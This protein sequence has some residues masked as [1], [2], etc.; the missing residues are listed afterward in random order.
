M[1]SSFGK[2]TLAVIVICLM[3]LMP[4][5]VAM[6][7]GCQKEKQDNIVEIDSFNCEVESKQHLSNPKIDE[8]ELKNLIIERVEQLQEQNYGIG[9]I[10]LNWTDP[11]GPL[12][13]GLDDIVDYINLIFGIAQSG[14]LLKIIL[15]GYI[16]DS[17]TFY[18]FILWIILYAANALNILIVFG[19]AFDVFEYG[20][21]DGR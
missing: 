7:D 13:G 10:G 3:M 4:L 12:E 21:G 16:R 19:E 8:D 14:Y 20:P 1:K 2:K 15:K 11:D 5:P 9:I 17:S 6:A 18:E